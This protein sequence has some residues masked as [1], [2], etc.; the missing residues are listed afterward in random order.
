MAPGSPND[1]ST[2]ASAPQ[3]DRSHYDFQSYMTP[4][5][6]ASLWRQVDLCLSYQPGQILE[7]GQGTGIFK[8][9]LGD[10]AIPVT[11]VDIAEDLHPDV[12]ASVLDLPF[13]D[14]SYDLTC[15]F[16]VL[17]HLP[18]EQFIP[19]VRELARVA[20]RAVLI[21]LPDAAPGYP[22]MLS[23]PG[24]GI[25]DGIVPRPYFKESHTFDGEHHWELNKQATPLKRV[26][27]DIENA[28]FR[29]QLNRRYAANMYHRFFILKQRVRQ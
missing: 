4:Y 12:I 11:T 6:W 14:S 22:T 29:I 16:Q 15:A 7:V 17:E 9:V 27:R 26:V 13:E 2:E 1:S 23:I 8:K 25:I 18:Y 20:R 5:R 28:G 24:F 10:N 21:S 19:A 3:V